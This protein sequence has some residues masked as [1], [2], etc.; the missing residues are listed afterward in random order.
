MLPEP[1][2]RNVVLDLHL[3]TVWSGFTT[4]QQYYDEASRWA[5]EIRSLVPFY[6]VIVGEMSLATGLDNYSVEQRQTFASK[7][8]A[9]FRDNALGYV[10]WSYKLAFA[11]AD[12]SFL[13]AAP[14]IKDYYKV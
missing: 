6:P 1:Q 12:W 13:D 9:S 5:E 10:F 7:E 4:L 11:S 3:Y 8:M 2:Y 14:Y